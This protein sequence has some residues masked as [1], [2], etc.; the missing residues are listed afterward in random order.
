MFPIR[1]QNPTS[2]TAYVTI[3]LVVLNCLIFLFEAWG[4]VDQTKFTYKYGFVPAQLVHGSEGLREE[5]REHP[6]MRQVRD[7]RGRPLVHVPSRRPVMEPVPIPIQTIT[8]IPAWVNIFTCMFLH[9]GWMHLIGNMLY[10]WIFGNNIEDRLGSVLF[11]VFY[12]GTGVVGNLAHTVFDPGYM[13]L[14]GASGAISGVMGAYILLFPRTRILAIVPIG[15][16]PMT[17]SL[18]AWIFLGFYFLIQNVY[19]TY[20]TVGQG[21]VAYWAHIGGF[22]SGMALIFVFPHR[23]RP[24]VAQPAYDPD[25][26]DADLVI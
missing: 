17:V 9:G 20:F 12:L 11:I 8:A 3:G 18:P 24:P 14:V 15:W 22:V 5:L 26:D 7:L 19:S 25:K 6:P 13:P 23:K 21:N 4:P 2:S 10:L 1:D 16:Y